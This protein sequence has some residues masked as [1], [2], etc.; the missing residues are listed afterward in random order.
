MHPENE[1][2]SP[3]AV[4]KKSDEKRKKLIVPETLLSSRFRFSVPLYFPNG[5]LTNTSN[6]SNKNT[7]YCEFAF[8]ICSAITVDSMPVIA[9][10]DR[11]INCTYI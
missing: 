1:T 10:G 4:P 3:D 2:A 7:L 11:E 5:V 8:V 9:S 6:V